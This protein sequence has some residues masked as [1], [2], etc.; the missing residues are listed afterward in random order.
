MR[1]A[2]SKDRAQSKPT[3]AKNSDRNLLSFYFPHTDIWIG[4]VTRHQ[5]S[6]IAKQNNVAH[7][8][9]HLLAILHFIFT[10]FY[11]LSTH[12]N[13]KQNYIACVPPP[14]VER[15]YLV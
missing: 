14:V 6:L 7:I 4:R 13:L 1:R 5:N 2:T 3:D 9:T 15:C 8:N 12:R 11:Y 10:T